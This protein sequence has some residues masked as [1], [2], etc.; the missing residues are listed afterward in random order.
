MDR[1]WY[2]I[3]LEKTS[4]FLQHNFFHQAM[5]TQRTLKTVRFY[6]WHCTRTP[7]RNLF[8]HK[9]AQIPLGHIDGY[10][11]V[12]G[13]FLIRG[14]YFSSARLELAHQTSLHFQ[15]CLT[16]W[17]NKPQFH[18][19]PII[20]SPWIIFH[21]HHHYIYFENVHFF[22]A[23]FAHMRSLYT[24]LKTAHSGGKPSTFYVIIHTLFPS[25]PIPPLT[26]H[27][28]ATSTFLQDNTQSSTL[29]RS[30]CPN[31]SAMPH[32]IHMIAQI[33]LCLEKSYLP[34]NSW[35]SIPNLNNIVA[36]LIQ[37]QNN[38]GPKLRSGKREALDK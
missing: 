19:G 10:S 17:A 9:R 36:Y 32:H 21:H 11:I 3:T 27:A 23:T 38:W 25:I 18:I 14:N 4:I 13:E 31:Q 34:K 12:E 1:E 16:N 30:R 24:S 29:L 35:N 8:H 2:M 6:I 15:E 37:P 20:I 28:L 7:N 33:I 22:Q 5:C 26:S